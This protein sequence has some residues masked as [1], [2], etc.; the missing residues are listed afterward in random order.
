MSY[1]NPGLGVSYGYNNGYC[2]E[3]P[4]PQNVW[5]QASLPAVGVEQIQ[6]TWFNSG[7]SYAY[8]PK[9]ARAPAASILYFKLGEIESTLIRGYRC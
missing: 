2:I 7:S 3:F 5:F 9:H 6:L 1:K 4:A 8:D